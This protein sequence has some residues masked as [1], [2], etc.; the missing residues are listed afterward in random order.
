M[1]LLAYHKWLLRE[2][3]GSREKLAQLILHDLME[4]Q[5]PMAFDLV[6]LTGDESYNNHTLLKAA[7]IL[8]KEQ[9]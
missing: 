3:N 5:N 4:D 1:K 7:D 6:A 9:G 8:L 2:A